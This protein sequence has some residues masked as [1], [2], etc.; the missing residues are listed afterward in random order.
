MTVL[1][2]SGGE[3]HPYR[4]AK[5]VKPPTW[6]LVFHKTQ[7]SPITFVPKGQHIN[8]LKLGPMRD[9]LPRMEAALFADLVTLELALNV[10][11][12]ACCF[13]VSYSKMGTAGLLSSPRNPL[14]LGVIMRT[15]PLTRCQ[16][17]SPLYS[18]CI[19]GLGYI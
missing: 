16:V 19:V 15:N 9:A 7:T 12:Y 1:C 10:Y 8:E 14:T 18:R 13:Q 5:A 6:S 2:G 3:F 17:F 4:T 11:P